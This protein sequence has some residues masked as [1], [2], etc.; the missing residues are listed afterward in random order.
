[1]SNAHNAIL[2][3]L[4]ASYAQGQRLVLVFDYDGT[5]TPIVSHPSV[6]RIYPAFRDVL[7]RL[8]AAPRITVGVVSGRSLDD[9]M[10]MVGLSELCYGGSTGLELFLGGERQPLPQA[11]ENCTLL[12]FLIAALEMRRIS[13][14]GMWL[15]KK[16]FGFTVH[17]RQL[18]EK[19]IERLRIETLVLLENYT[20]VLH[21]LD[22]P[23]AI[24]VTPA[25]GRDKG[26]ALRAIVAHGGPE[27]ATVLYAGDAANDA[28]AL[29]VATELGGIALGLG[30]EP[31][32][33]ATQ[34]LA[35]PVALSE[36][37]AALA[38]SILSGSTA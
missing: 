26:T 22:G 24:E 21:V 18:A 19:L 11:L 33:E 16:P 9:V 27:P 38:M 35:D 34:R 2:K 6:A 20:D 28:P 32:K 31:P 30:S 37:L 29:A 13:Y 12:H 17:Y 25:I 10:G 8:A 7:A 1:M 3:R 15:E 23:L 5:L 14:P 4:S 36:L